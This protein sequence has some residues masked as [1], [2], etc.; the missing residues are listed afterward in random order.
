MIA[1]G[2]RT[3]V[4][5]GADVLSNSWG[6]GAASTAITNAFRFAQTDG[7]GGKGCAIAVATGNIDARGVS[8]PANLSPSV[9]GLLAVGASNEWDE[10]KSRTSRDGENWWGS[11]WGPEIDV[12]AP[13]VHIFTT[14]IMGG[15]GYG[16]GNYI[17]NFNGTSSA[18][19]HV[20][21]LM[22]LLLSVDPNLRAWEVEDIVKLTAAEL[23]S[24]GR[25]EHFGFGRIDCRRALEAALRIAVDIRATPVFYGPGR[26]CFI[27]C[28]ARVSN[29]GINHVRLD[30]L[31]LRSHAPDGTV[32]DQLDVALNPGGTMAP[33]TGQDAVVQGLLLR[34]NGNSSS[35]SYRWTASWSYT[36]WRPGAPALPLTAETPAG[37]G[38]SDER[39]MEGSDEG[40][41]S[42]RT[43]APQAARSYKASAES[44]PSQSIA[45]ERRQGAI[46]IIIQ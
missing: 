20:A 7:R 6:G 29:P 41:T 44:E 38:S 16:G 23:G 39:K 22:A 14:D 19:P 15:A 8:Y 46:T 45:I 33:R 32:M 26:D 4:T 11:S 35:W 42:E 10:R 21:G 12:V 43:A 40:G 24:A 13:G 3:A 17:P 18:T 31:T 36:F 27:K 28:R 5:R 25:D 9:P 37:A 30:K 1:D 34:G 2:I